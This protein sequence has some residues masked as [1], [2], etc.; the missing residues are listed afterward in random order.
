MEDHLSVS[1]E[2]SVRPARK[3]GAAKR[4]TIMM[5]VGIV[6]L[7][8]VIG[9][10]LYVQRVVI[11]ATVDGSPITRLSVIRQLEQQNGK[12]ALDSLITE[13]LIETEAA[14]KAIVVSDDE[15]GEEIKKIEASIVGQGGT[16][17]DALMQKG[18]TENTLRRQVRIQ[19]EVQ[20]LLAD[21][22][23]ITPGEVSKF[24]SDNKIALPKEKNQEA[25]MRTQIESQLQNQKFG[26]EAQKLISALKAQAKIIYYANY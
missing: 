10:L 1:P 7:G 12:G 25:E 19:K 18:L 15:I 3:E 4:R 20:K 11:A 16:L 13:K 8:L 22:I 24:I 5:A 6:I 14:K 9:G 21:K 26:E 17:K 2:R 23:K